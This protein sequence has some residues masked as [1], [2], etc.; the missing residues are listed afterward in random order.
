VTK[1]QDSSSQEGKSGPRDDARPKGRARSW[2]FPRFAQD[3]PKDPE[4][5]RLVDAFARGDYRTVRDDAP[6]LAASSTDE[7]VK[8]AAERLLEGTRPEPA[9]RL[10]FVL[11]ALLLVFLAAWWMR[12]DHPEPERTTAPPPAPTVEYVH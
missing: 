2:G 10:L 3:F 11:T 7:D 5:D 9:A 8:R 1:A 4:L 12:H 6:K